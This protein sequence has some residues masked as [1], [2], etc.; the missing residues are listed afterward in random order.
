MPNEQVTPEAPETSETPTVP[1]TSSLLK[2][3]TDPPAT[4]EATPS[5]N[6]LEVAG[7][8]NP[9]GSFVEDWHKS[10]KLPE[11]VRNSESLGVIKNLA[12]LAKRT[13][14]AEKM[15]GTSKIALPKAD[16]DESEWTFFFDAVGKANPAYAKPETPGDYKFDVPEGMEN[17]YSED[18]MNQSKEIAHK[19]GVTQTQFEQFMQ[20]DVEAMAEVVNAQIIEQGRIDDENALALKKEWGHAYP[21][22]QHVVKRAIAEHFGA[23]K[24]SEMEFLKNYAGNPDVVRILAGLGSRLVESKSM[25][26]ELTQS[27]PDQALREIAELRS[28]QGYMSMGSD[29]TDEQRTEITNRIRDKY[30]EAYPSG[31]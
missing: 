29:M 25:V 24:T 2:T 13:V 5:P 21:E 23:D 6:L 7:L 22:M 12:D 4:P 1:E 31:K 26:A 10:D 20:A 17:I 9:D 30:K 16:A 8:V 15:V 28:T 11:D 19:I 18:K 3:P 27:T 14:H